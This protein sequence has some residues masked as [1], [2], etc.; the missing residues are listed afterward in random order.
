MTVY[1]YGNMTRTITK[2]RT[3]IYSNLMTLAPTK[4]KS[5]NRGKV[6]L[7]KQIYVNI[8]EEEA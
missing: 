8:L 3:S 5:K 4:I 7:L 6:F 2:T 1:P